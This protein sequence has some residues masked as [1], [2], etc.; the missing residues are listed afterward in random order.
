MKGTEI[1]GKWWGMLAGLKV[2]I[3]K[4]HM[5]PDGWLYNAKTNFRNRLHKS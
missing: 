2:Y 4:F 3:Y 5:Q 1:I